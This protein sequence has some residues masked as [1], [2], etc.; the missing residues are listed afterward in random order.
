MFSEMGVH[1]VPLVDSVVGMRAGFSASSGHSA[2]RVLVDEFSPPVRRESFERFTEIGGRADGLVWDVGNRADIDIGV[3][4]WYECVNVDDPDGNG[5]RKRCQACS[6]KR[7]QP[8]LSLC[9]FVEATYLL[10]P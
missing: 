7:C 3:R 1:A 6:G 10:R 4:C 2:D 8:G 5:G 9:S